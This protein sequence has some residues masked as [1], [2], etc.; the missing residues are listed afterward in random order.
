MSK[1]VKFKIKAQ[2]VEEV[3]R[4]LGAKGAQEFAKEID[5]IVEE[6]ALN[7]VNNARHNAPIDT[8]ALKNSI[9]IYEEGELYRVVGSD[10]PYAQRQEYEHATKKGYFRK[11]LWNEREPFRKDIQDAIKRLDN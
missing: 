8:S 6:H 3:L 10:R 1:G 5:Q 2:G 4:K 7:I 11:A 9:D